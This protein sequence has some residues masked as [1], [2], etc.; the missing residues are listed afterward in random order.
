MVI[1]L[2]LWCFD[3]WKVQQT[4]L[5]NIP[6]PFLFLLKSSS[7][8]AVFWLHDVQGYYFTCFFWINLIFIIKLVHSYLLFAVCTK[9][10]CFVQRYK[11][12][13]SY[14]LKCSLLDNS[15][16]CD[17]VFYLFIFIQASC[18]RCVSRN[19][20]NIWINTYTCQMNICMCL[21]EKSPYCLTGSYFS[22]GIKCYLS[23]SSIYFPSGYF[24]SNCIFS[25]ASGYRI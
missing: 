12:H 23:N 19:G 14:I 9:V 22:W 7:L 8:G 13:I 17:S 4:S 10:D 5:R 2:N 11:Y 1:R 24:L 20:M 25:S 6:K 15:L 21:Y 16:I 18:K 3:I